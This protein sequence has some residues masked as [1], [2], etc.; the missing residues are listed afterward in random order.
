[1]NNELQE[2]LA[3]LASMRLIA[4]A[5]KAK[6]AAAKDAF[7]RDNARAINTAK[8][9]ATRAEELETKARAL[10]LAAYAEFGDTRPAP[11]INIGL[12]KKVALTYDTWR[13]LAWARETNMALALDIKA[14]E[15]IAEAA[16]LEFVTKTEVETQ[17][18]AIAS[19]L[20]KLYYL[21]PAA[22][23]AEEPTP[24]FT[25]GYPQEEPEGESHV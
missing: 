4:E 17:R 14:F 12:G 22:V 15:K 21:P 7:E 10:A 1:M 25:P 3:A 6:L 20:T 23:I 9:A 2:T 11:G 19:D 13:A 24:V 8:A 5:S 18:V 16:N